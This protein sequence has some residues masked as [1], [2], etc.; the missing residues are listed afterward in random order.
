MKNIHVLYTNKPSYLYKEDDGSLHYD[1][2]LQSYGGV[3]H[4]HLYITS[5]EEIKEEDWLINIK[6]NNGEPFKKDF[7]YDSNDVWYKK[8][9]LTTD[10]ELIE[11]GVQAIPDE[12]LYWFIKNPNCEEVEI[13]E[14]VRYEDEWIDNEDGG[15]IYQH[16]YC[17]YKIIIP[18]EESK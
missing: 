3:D 14:G 1:E 9:I 11:D 5:N 10:D 7:K 18:K 4:Y 2:V 8:I 13:G 15:E 17:C 6:L 12:F 16:Q